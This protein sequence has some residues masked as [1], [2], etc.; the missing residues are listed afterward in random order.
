MLTKARLALL[1]VAAILAACG[2]KVPDIQDP[3]NPVVNGKAMTQ[4]EFLDT[5]C[6]GDNKTAPSCTRIMV[7]RRQS[8]TDGPMPKWP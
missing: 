6:L 4:R 8:V 1:A 5:Y 7:D 2:D 3:K